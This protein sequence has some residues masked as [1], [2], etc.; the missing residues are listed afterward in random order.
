[1][2]AGA[3]SATG[4]TRMTEDTNPFEREEAP[5]EQPNAADPVAVKKARLTDKRL[6]EERARVLQNLLANP[7]GRRFFAHILHDVCGM[8]V[9]TAN[10]A[11]DPYGQHFR[12]GSR[13]VGLVLHQMALQHAGPQ[14]MVVLHENLIKP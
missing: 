14:Y 3:S 11:F 12:E 2:S 10:R 1:M 8:Y 9:P 6:R 13:A 5:P 7:E 4:T